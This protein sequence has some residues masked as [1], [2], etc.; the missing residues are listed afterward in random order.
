MKYTDTDIEQ[1]E[2][3][4]ITTEQLTTQLETLKKG[5]TY[6]DLY[7]AASL[8]DGILQLDPSEQK[9]YATL[10]ESRKDSLDLLKFTPASGAATRMFRFLFEFL[11]EYDAE[12]ESINAYINKKEAKD[13]RLFFVG[14]DNFPFYNKVRKQLKKKYKKKKCTNINLNR[15]RFV[16]IMLN[17]DELNFGKKPKGLFPFHSYK[18]HVS[19][20]F[21]EHLF[22]G[23]TYADKNKK[24]RLHFTISKDHKKYFEQQFEKRKE[25]IERKTGISFS[26]TYSYQS[27]AT[28][29]IALDS[30]DSVLRNSSNEIIFRP[31]GH[32]ALIDNLNNQNA[33]LIFIKNIDNVVVFKYQ[34]DVAFYK[35]MLAGKLLELQERSFNYQ[36]KI[37]QN[38]DL[39]EAKITE[40][41]TFLQ[42][43]LSIKIAEDFEKYSASYKVIYLKQ[44][45]DRPMRVCAMVP[46]EGEPGGGPFWIR[47]KNGKKSLQ[48][49]ESVQID[50]TNEQQQSILKKATHFNPVDIVC[51][52]K[53]YKGEKYD[54]QKFVDTNASFIT[55]KSYEGKKI[56]ALEHPGLWNGGMA[57]WNTVFIEAPLITFNPVKTVNDLLKP[58]HQTK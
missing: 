22:E 12:K 18:H 4:G 14:L 17:E 29:T 55:T 25:Y 43:E 40:I 10:F 51:G 52:I 34:E 31:G 5:V 6:I 11:D 49:I 39:K 23:A 33:D 38:K 46:N 30:D 2:E 41:T 36:L 26:I 9:K 37:D 19:T 16:S 44:I 28:D 45:L 50:P 13:L 53:N 48:I 1:L 27:K 54:L 42:N 32:G 47:S 3:R 8:E 24:A 21:E 56:K 58:A 20:A 15:Q 7:D 57:H 35:K